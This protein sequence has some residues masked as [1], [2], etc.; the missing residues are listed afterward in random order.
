MDIAGELVEQGMALAFRRYSL[1][2]ADHEDRAREARR[3]LWG[4][5]FVEPWDWRAALVPR[6]DARSRGAV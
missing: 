5:Q 4:G 3:G 1:A 6:A 2:Y